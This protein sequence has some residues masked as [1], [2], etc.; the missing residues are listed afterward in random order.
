MEEHKHEKYI[1]K[2]R[3]VSLEGNERAHIR[4]EL[5][6]YMQYHPIRVVS[7]YGEKTTVKTGWFFHHLSYLA[8][9]F[10]TVAL[11]LGGVTYAAEGS[12]PGNSLYSVK[13]SVNEEVLGWFAFGDEAKAVWEARRAE[14][15]LEEAEQL[16]VAGD[17]SAEARAT[18]ATRLET[19]AKAAAARLG[20]LASADGRTAAR[21][22]SELE[23]SLRAHEHI[24]LSLDG[25]KSDIE[26]HE[27]A[28]MMS[29]EAAT[30]TGEGNSTSQVSISTAGISTLV[31]Q[32]RLSLDDIVSVRVQ[33]EGNASSD[34]I[35]DATLADEFM[36]AAEALG[37]AR[38]MFESRE[39]TL[40]SSIAA[41]AE[42]R[43]RRAEESLAE[44][45]VALKEQN[46]AAALTLLRTS[47]RAATE[48]RILARTSARI[49][50]DILPGLD[51]KLEE[52]FEGE[53]IDTA[54]SSER[55]SSTAPSTKGQG[56]SIIDILIDTDLNTD[57][58]A[59]STTIQ[60]NNQ[61]TSTSKSSTSTSVKN[62]N[63]ASVKTEVN[64]KIN[65]G[66]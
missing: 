35:E 59:S 66:L 5:V 65:T 27:M 9:G 49:D 6:A 28:T 29:M 38:S 4:A 1:A 24:L 12:M 30:D 22:S 34:D 52:H 18:L 51:V 50:I 23:S 54:T 36:R 42:L 64:V 40:K 44:A 31:A 60:Q 14:R 62:T 47:I 16:A 46:R 56:A 21:V 33:A 25:V 39:A 37:S 19:H 32:V 26:P 58:E 41:E 45:E 57:S 8:T 55:G 63:N 48:A 61:A 53:E 20:K 3:T 13:V 17:L 11:L 10:A 2:L 15:R 7:S 43:L